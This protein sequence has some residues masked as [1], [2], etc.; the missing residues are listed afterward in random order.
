MQD[1]QD[2]EEKGLE[3]L[4]VYR[5]YAQSGEKVREDL[6]LSRLKQDGQD[7]QDIQDE[8]LRG[9]GPRTTVARAA[10]LLN[11]SARACPS[12]ASQ[13]PLRIKGLS[14]LVILFPAVSIDIKVFQ[15]FSPHAQAAPSCKSWPSWPSCFRQLNAR[16]LLRSYGPCHL[17]PADVYRH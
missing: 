17:V 12:H 15:T 16:G 2:E 4:N 7:L 13:K 10:R 14:D 1:G 8:R 5:T 6:N 11:R 3:D 9:T